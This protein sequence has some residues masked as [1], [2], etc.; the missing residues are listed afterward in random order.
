MYH[1]Y[2]DDMLLFI[3]LCWKNLVFIFISPQ[4]SPHSV[5]G[6]VLPCGLKANLFE[7]Q[8]CYHNHFWANVLRKVTE[9]SYSLSYGLN[10]TTA[11]LLQGWL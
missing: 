1:S 2:S 3:T 9:P 5:M 6:K 10:S 8:S 4:S 11:V 7:L